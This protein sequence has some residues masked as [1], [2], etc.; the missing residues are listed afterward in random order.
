MKIVPLRNHS[1]E[2]VKG[3]LFLVFIALIVFLECRKKLGDK[4]K[5]SLEQVLMVMRNLKGKVFDTELLTTELTKQQKEIT[6]LFNVIVP[7][8]LGI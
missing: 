6:H 8:K 2:T 1:D 3:Y 7:K 4:N 5:Y